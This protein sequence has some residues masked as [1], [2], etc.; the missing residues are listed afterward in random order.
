M[1]YKK[2]LFKHSTHY[3]IGE[4]LVILAS[5]I[6]FPILTRIFSKEQYGQMSLI[7][8]LL[9]LGVTFA[10]GGF[11]QST[12]R[13][14][15]EFSQNKRKCGVNVFYST[16]FWA[17]LI[18]SL[19]V[20]TGIILLSFFLPDST[21]SL[22]TKKIVRFTA[23]IIVFQ[24]LNKLFL[25]FY[26]SEQKTILY[27]LCYIGKQYLSLGGSLAL[28][29]FVVANL[30]SL[31]TGIIVAEG[32]FVIFFIFAFMYKKKVNFYF[33]SK[34]FLKEAVFFGFPFMFLNSA[35]LLFDSG[36]KYIIQY[37]KGFEAVGI[38]SVGYSLSSYVQSAIVTPFNM[39]IGP[40]CM[41]IWVKHGKEATSRFLSEV[42]YYFI[43]VSGLTVLIL[44]SIRKEILIVLASTKFAEAHVV[45][46]FVIIGVMLYGIYNIFAR[47]L[48]IYKKIILLPIGI[49]LSAVLNIVL[50]V[51]LIPIWGI[52]G[53]A[54]AT[55]FSY[56]F[57]VFSTY[58]I[59][60]KYMK[61]EFPWAI[62]IKCSIV[63]LC[64]HFF[65]LRVHLFSGSKLIII[66]IKTV[67]LMVIYSGAIVLVDEKIRNLIGKLFKTLL[68]KIN[69][70]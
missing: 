61:I 24:T 32:I 60:S 17:S 10:N 20:M 38:Y 15:N 21:F 65:L 9:G 34:S 69:H 46:P 48:F 31:Y 66:I 18:L 53:A 4:I 62:I 26:R 42:L 30:Y 25:S 57:L 59:T 2:N 41:E 7:S 39:A 35:F 11:Q 47:V 23:I 3:F 6:S 33:F 51:F 63:A 13:F 43:A 16:F 68:D 29:F 19:F 37:Y 52:V 36:D 27:N 22:G 28:I 67:I 56:M 55:L 44:V 1:S 40:L 49:L 5:V 8:V 14:F 54:V 70:R 45:V 58:L 12:V 50:N 64:S